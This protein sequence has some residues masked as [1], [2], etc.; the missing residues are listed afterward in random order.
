MDEKP[1]IRND[2]GQLEKGSAPLPGAGRPRKAVEQAYLNAIAEIV[3]PERWN[4]I[5][6]KAAVD[7]AKGYPEARRWLSDYLIGKPPQILELRAGDAVLLKQVLE[8]FERQGVPASDVFHA[9][10]ATFAEAEEVEEYADDEH[11]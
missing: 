3:T 10:L 1:V 2:K 5:V 8:N 9:M 7:A 6:L 11:E 4:K